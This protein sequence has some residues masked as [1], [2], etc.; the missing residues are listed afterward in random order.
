MGKIPVERSRN[1]TPLDSYPERD[2]DISGVFEKRFR[3]EDWV[4]G[5]LDLVFLDA[6]SLETGVL[7]AD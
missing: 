4:S 6:L 3:P 2:E 7:I 5:N 1:H